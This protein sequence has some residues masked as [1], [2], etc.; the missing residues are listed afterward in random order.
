VSLPT[1]AAPGDYS[2]D[3]Q[4]ADSSGNTS[5]VPIV[6]RSLVPLNGG[7]GRF[8]GTIVGGDGD[9]GLATTQTLAFNVP[10]GAPFLHVQFNVP[11]GTYP[12]LWSYLVS[13]DGQAVGQSEIPQ[14]TG[15]QVLQA[16]AIHPQPGQWKFVVAGL[17]PYGGNAV[18]EPF[19]G[20]VSLSPFPIRVSGVPDSSRSRIPAGGSTTAS[21][22]VTNTGNTDV[23]LFLDPRLDQHRLYSLS[24]LT[25]ATGVAL[26]LSLSAPPL[27]PVPTETNLLLASAQ[28]NVPIT[29]NWGFGDPD[30]EAASHGDS[31]SGA[32]AA[33]PTTSGVWEITPAIIGPI[34]PTGETGTVS[35]GMAA[36]T[37][38]FD[39]SVSTPNGDPLTLDV[40]PDA[41][42]ENPVDLAPGASSTIPVTFTSS[43]R[44]GS[45]VSGDLFVDDYQ[46]NTDSA[47]ELGDI[48]YRYRVGR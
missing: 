9:G 38:V 34:S 40:N 32:F 24:A 15:N 28:A 26:P 29:F 17:D 48:P 2:R 41:V 11:D 3:L 27:F 22:K 18:S 1:P 36:L 4:I 10:R 45:V 37:R 46:Y 31:A 39:T 14:V 8:S 43:G 44:R 5:V 13:P 30:L 7:S 6:S 23:Q 21:V 33:N 35:T 42:V 12:S 16:T 19:S 25:Q 20:S 47:N